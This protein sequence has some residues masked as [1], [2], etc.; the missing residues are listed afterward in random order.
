MNDKLQ[1]YFDCYSKYP[2][3]AMSIVRKKSVC[4]ALPFEFV[5][6]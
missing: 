4:M 1:C 3:T 2:T 6:N 5:G